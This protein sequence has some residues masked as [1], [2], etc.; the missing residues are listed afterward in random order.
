[1]LF[2]AFFPSMMSLATF[3]FVAMSGLPPRSGW[4]ICMSYVVSEREREIGGNDYQRKSQKR[5]LEIPDTATPK[6]P[7][8]LFF[9]STEGGWTKT[10]KRAR[11]E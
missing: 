5:A 1:M 7:L 6:E 9:S 10:R 11:M 2:G 3:S 4:L 8:N